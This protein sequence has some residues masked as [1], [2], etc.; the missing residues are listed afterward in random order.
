M[1][2]YGEA[3]GIDRLRRG[4]CRRVEE[5]TVRELSGKMRDPGV[6]KGI[7]Q[8]GMSCVL[9][10]SVKTEQKYRYLVAL[11]RLYGCSEE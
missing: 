7:R 6:I 8:D 2:L 9:Q 11:S 5:V 1:S 4:Y 3:A 10:D